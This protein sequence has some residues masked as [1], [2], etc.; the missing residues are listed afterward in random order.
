MEAISPLYTADLFAPLHQE[1]IRL[2]HGLTAEDWE[3]PTVAGRWRVRDVVAH[4]I[5]VDL[6]KLSVN[7][8]GH[9]PAPAEPIRGYEELVRFLDGLNAEW[10]GAARRLS[11]R[12]L[13]E[14]LSFT[15]PLISALV[16]SLPHHERSVFSVSWAGESESENWF[17]IGRDYTERWHHQ[18]QIRDA[19]GAP[20]LLER[21][22]L[23]PLLDLSFRALP[24]AYRDIHATSGTAVTV[25]VTG[26]AGGAWTLLRDGDKWQLCRGAAPDSAA[27]VTLDPDSAWRLLYNALPASEARQRSHTEG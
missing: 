5:D 14:L 4:L 1:L 10:V 17:D 6:R 23:Y 18:M 3:R 8:D 27:V 20:L 25:R 7:R 15:G 21:R 22:W 19:V 16:A 9:L 24:H 11:P 2:L 13:I 12:V 26:D